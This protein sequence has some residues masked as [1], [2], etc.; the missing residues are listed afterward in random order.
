MLTIDPCVN[1]ELLEVAFERVQKD[2]DSAQPGDSS[3]TRI[4]NFSRSSRFQR[5]ALDCASD[6]LMV[7]KFP[8]IAHSV[9]GL[10]TAGIL[11][12]MEVQRSV[13]EV[14]SLEN[15]Y[16]EDRGAAGSALPGE[17]QIRES[18]FCPSAVRH[19]LGGL[20]SRLGSGQ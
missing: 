15:L 10:L 7:R 1:A 5:W 16:T 17:R 9:L 14:G 13:S 18:D 12:G 4:R 20:G 8:D 3:L 19:E 11:V 2:L 6:L